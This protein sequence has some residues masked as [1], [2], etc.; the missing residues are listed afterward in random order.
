[1][2]SNVEDFQSGAVANF[3]L[4]REIANC[5]EQLSLS[6]TIVAEQMNAD[7]HWLKK[8][9]S[10]LDTISASDLYRLCQVLNISMN[11]VYSRVFEDQSL[12]QESES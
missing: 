1:M 7:Y 4:G 6:Q 11:E 5:R 10:G 3:L 2:L 8:I 9:E 12:S